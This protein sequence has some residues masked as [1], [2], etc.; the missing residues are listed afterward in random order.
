MNNTVP[1]FSPLAVILFLVIT[2]FV[3]GSIVQGLVVGLRGIRHPN[4]TSVLYMAIFA[5]LAWLGGLLALSNNGFFAEFERMPP[6]IVLAL[7]VPLATILFLMFKRSFGELLDQLSPAALIYL[8]AFRILVEVV[9]WLLYRDGICPPQMTFEGWNFDIVAGL[10]APLAA[11][12]AFGGG[13]RNKAIAIGYNI[14][15]L[16][17]LTTIILIAILSFPQIGVLTP[18]NRMIAYWPMIWLP[19]FV[20][21]FALLLHLFSLRQLLRMK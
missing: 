14:V 3:F 6:R 2:V 11:W 21:P 20:A 12:A 10:L 13:R 5:M 16:C 1:P 19:G 9:L 17:L 7:A 4:Y 8:Q 15:G 18:P